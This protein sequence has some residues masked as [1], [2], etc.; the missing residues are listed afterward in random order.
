MKFLFPLPL[1]QGYQVTLLGS[2]QKLVIIKFEESKIYYEKRYVAPEFCSIM[3]VNWAEGKK[4][5]N[6]PYKHE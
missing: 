2:I 1:P 6:F 3:S 5:N 4:L